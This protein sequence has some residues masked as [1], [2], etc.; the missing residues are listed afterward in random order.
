MIDTA[1]LRAEFG[2]H[3]DGKPAF[4][5]APGRVN[6][7]GEHTDYNEG[8]V[9]PAALH[10]DTGIGIA[11]HSGARLR[12]RSR[13]F[14]QTVEIPLDDADAL[15]RTSGRGHWS[16][17]VIGVVIALQKRGMMFGGADILV[18][19]DIPL[20]AGLSS[21]A[22]FEVAVAFALLDSNGLSL[23]KMA[24]AQLCQH[25]ENDHVGARCGIMDQ[26]AAAF[27]LKNHALALDC[28]TLDYRPVPLGSRMSIIVCNTL[29]RHA[30]AGGEYNQRRADCESAVLQLSRRTPGLRSLRDVSMVELIDQEPHLD[31]VAWRRARTNRTTACATISRSVAPNS[32]CSWSLP[33]TP[34]AC[35]VR[36]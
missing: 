29:V 17:Y 24:L 32:T 31:P 15:N 26:F 7:I 19:S 2:R 6:L 10:F 13:E 12:V 14:D 20:G 33:R 8:F 34:T 36:A 35:T 4:Y 3:F 22:S 18:G 5:R 27:G 11:P 21:S 16:D 1:Q 30:H 9:M 28:R 23:D 25:A